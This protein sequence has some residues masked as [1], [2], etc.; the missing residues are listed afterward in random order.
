MIDKLLE[1]VVVH[2]FFREICT[3][4]WS[5]RSITLVGLKSLIDQAHLPLGIVEYDCLVISTILSRKEGIM[6]LLPDVGRLRLTFEQF[7]GRLAF[8]Q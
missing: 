5:T 3:N 8:D 1:E 7:A 6:I 2:H 4:R